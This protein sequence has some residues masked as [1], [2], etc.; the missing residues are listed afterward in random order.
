MNCELCVETSAA[1]VEK[2]ILRKMRLRARGVK[3]SAVPVKVLF[4]IKEHWSRCVL[5]GSAFVFHESD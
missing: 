3:V 5:L 1:L 4:Y 2:L